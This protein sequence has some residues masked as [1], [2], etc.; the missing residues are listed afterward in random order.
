MFIG[1]PVES[2]AAALHAAC[3]RD[4]PEIAYV[5][6]D[7]PAYRALI[8]GMTKEEKLAHYEKERSTG[9]AAGP[10]VTRHRRPTP[11]ACRVVVFPQT[12]GSTALGFGGIGGQ[13]ISE[14]YTTVVDAPDCRM[15]AVYFGGSGRLAYLV[16]YGAQDA[17]F[18]AC[19]AEQQMPSVA[20][21][22]QRGWLPVRE[23]EAA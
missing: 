11:D 16:P 13:A 8:N 3:L 15:R 21:A 20:D 14:A 22:A 10:T 7:W 19:M 17:A 2:I 9:V 18:N 12:W 5:D 23:Q 1:S 4:L 6:R